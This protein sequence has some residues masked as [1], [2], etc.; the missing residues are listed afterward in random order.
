[1]PGKDQ[2]VRDAIV[3]GR[4]EVYGDPK[5]CHTAIGKVWGAQLC[6]DDIPEHM[7]VQMLAGMKLVRM[8]RKYHKDNYDDIANYL[9]FAQEWQEEYDNGGS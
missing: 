7:V 3:E 2:D 4:E 9:D 6:I 5:S 8:R 1:M